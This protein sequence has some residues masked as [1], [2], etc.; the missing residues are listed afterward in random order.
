MRIILLIHTQS[1]LCYTKHDG[2]FALKESIGN[3]DILGEFIFDGNR[4]TLIQRLFYK[5]KTCTIYII[6]E[7]YLCTFFILVN[8]ICTQYTV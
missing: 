1:H 2:T 7:V 5:V 8:L 6:I 3:A 4:I